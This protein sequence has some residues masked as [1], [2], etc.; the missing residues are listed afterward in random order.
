MTDPS[1][2]AGPDDLRELLS[3]RPVLVVGRNS[4]CQNLVS[5][6]AAAA[7]LAGAL[8]A[9]ERRGLHLTRA[10]IPTEQ[11]RLI[12]ITRH[13]PNQPG[14]ALESPHRPADP[15]DAGPERAAAGAAG[16]GGW[17]AA[18]DVSASLPEVL[19]DQGNIVDQVA[20]VSWALRPLYTGAWTPLRI[21]RELVARHYP[22]VGLRRSRGPGATFD[23]PRTSTEAHFVPR[24]M[25]K[26]WTCT[27]PG[28]WNWAWVS[29]AWR[30]S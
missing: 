30:T 4:G 28:S 5:Y 2:F 20:N 21:A 10:L 27:S 17:P 8:E 12:Q 25:L 7:D 15:A 26:T 19:D 16:A 18:T 6:R 3:T 13:A 24:S 23:M 22:T 1:G 9:L 14:V 29:K 11:R